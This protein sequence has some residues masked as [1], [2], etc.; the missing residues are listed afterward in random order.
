[1][2][3]AN[4]LIVDDDADFRDSLK[5]FLERQGYRVEAAESEAAAL[6][7]LAQIS[8][9]ALITDLSLTGNSTQDGLRIIKAFKQLQPVRPAILITAFGSGDLPEKARAAGTDVYLEK[10]VSGAWLCAKLA[11]LGL[12]RK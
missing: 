4:L 5:V 9:A 8:F 10:P 12:A 11:E 3:T 7:K 6:E 1:M 2:Q